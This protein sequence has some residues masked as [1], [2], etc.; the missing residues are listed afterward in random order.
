MSKI[1]T[2]AQQKGGAGKTT[3]AA[4]IAV[5]IAQTGRSVAII[6][7]DPQASLT[8]WHK[9]REKK[10]GEGFTGLSFNTSPGWRVEAAVSNLK[11]KFDFIIIDS[12]PHTET[13]SKSAIRV[14]DLVVIPMQPSP[15]DLW[16]TESTVDFAN[17]EG[18]LTRILLNRFSPISK[19]NSEILSKVK[20]TLFQNYVGNRVA[21]SSCFLI[22][23]TVVET[24]PTSR[25]A[26]EI[27]SVVK[28][29]LKEFE[30][31]VKEKIEVVEEA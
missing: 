21:F 9:I 31:K 8:N 24:Q 12:P 7:V 15:T 5:S 22:G 29:V 17:S 1:I 16:A 25:A 27:K 18:K 11:R 26:L 23:L 6:D 30:P 14:A 20:G 3:I 2:I 13:E 4:H 28:E 19:I 10:F